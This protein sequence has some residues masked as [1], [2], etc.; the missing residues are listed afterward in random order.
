MIVLGIDPGT[1][2]LGWGVVLAEGNRTRHIDHGVLRVSEELP[3]EARLMHLD[4]A[5]G[6]VLRRFRPA[7]AAVEGLFFHKD[8]QAAAKLGH[9][10]GV[11]LLNVARE[12]VAL[13]E[14]AP[15]RVKQTLTGQGR[16][17]KDQMAKMV[18]I[19]L[20]LAEE[21]PHDAADALALALTHVRRAPL[22]AMLSRPPLPKSRRA[23]AFVGSR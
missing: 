17:T 16:A 21:P 13:A 19:L 23:P 11:V 8:A 7:A 4:L 15:A 14:Y 12:G 20:N 3:L 1:R 5:L 9:A 18:K 10:R 2:N 6:E 22:D